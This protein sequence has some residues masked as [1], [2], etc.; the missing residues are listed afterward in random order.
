MRGWAIVALVL[1]LGAGS[2][3]FP[4]KSFATNYGTGDHW[5]SLNMNTAQGVEVRAVTV[6]GFAWGNQRDVF[7]TSMEND[8]YIIVISAKSNDEEKYG[9]QLTSQGIS[10]PNATVNDKGVYTYTINLNGADLGWDKPDNSEN[11]T[12]SLSF[13]IDTYRPSVDGGDNPTEPPAWTDGQVYFVWADGD[14]EDGNFYYHK[15][16]NV[17]GGRVNYVPVGTITHEGAPGIT[18]DIHNRTRIAHRNNCEDREEQSYAFVWAPRNYEA[19]QNCFEIAK[20]LTN[21]KSLTT[22]GKFDYLI[23][24]GMTINS[25]G[26]QNGANSV[27][28]MGESAFTMIIYDDA[29]EGIQVGVPGEYSY[30]PSFWDRANHWDTVDVSGTT[31]D[32]PAQYETFLLEQTLQLRCAENW[33][34]NSIAYVEPL[35]V[36]SKA[37]TVQQNMSDPTAW[38]ITFNSRYYDEVELRVTDSS[39]QV[40]YLTL[41][42]SNVALKSL[43]TNPEG[44]YAAVYYPQ[45][46]NYQ[47]YQVV[48]K[49][50]YTDGSSETKVLATPIRGIEDENGDVQ[51]A[52]EIPGGENLRTAWFKLDGITRGGDPNVSSFFVTVVKDYVPGSEYSG[53]ILTGSGDGIEFADSGTGYKRVAKAGTDDSLKAGSNARPKDTGNDITSVVVTSDGTQITVSGTTR[54]AVAAS[55]IFVY[56]K[57]DATLTRLTTIAVNDNNAFSKTIPL[58][59]G[60]YV[61]RV[62]NYDGGQATTNN[63]IVSSQEPSVVASPPSGKSL[64]YN[65]KTQTGVAAG[66]G[67]ALSGTVSAKQAGSYAATAVLKDGYVWSD[68]TTAAKTISWRINKAA[69]PLKIKAKTATVKYSRLKSKNRALAVSKVIKFTKKTNDKKI[70]KLSSAKK[71]KKG[72][73][74]FKKYFK[75]NKTTG[76]VTVKKGLGKGTYKVKVKVKA[77]GNSNYK[78]SAWKTVTFTVKVK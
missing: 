8:A 4:T 48:L 13:D 75:V 9:I 24:R 20:D 1:V 45:N 22:T 32:A 58:E 47:D 26:A 3:L 57:D 27:C 2:I 35:N 78:A 53:G 33:I 71:G 7:K 36:P 12:C 25:A 15:I 21:F 14:A 72:K 10:I 51:D 76:K 65:G 34:S 68:G 39:G 11:Y 19:N 17:D 23:E 67:Y 74:S 60:A 63:V 69:N 70:Y 44:V 16:T 49:I 18:Y 6:N 5:L 46:D 56:K 42:R 59:E 73:K 38:D 29:Y 64:T 28:T 55:S 31:Q 66:E 37:V 43:R 77:K 30:Y 40:Y 41:I 62:A 54:D 61:V 50:N 52:Y